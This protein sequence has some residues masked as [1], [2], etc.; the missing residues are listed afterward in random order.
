MRLLHRS[1]E[2]CLL[3]LPPISS[4]L[5][6]EI[7]NGFEKNKHFIIYVIDRN[8]FL[9]QSQ[10]ISIKVA[11]NIYT[12]L[13]TKKSLQRKLNRTPCACLIISQFFYTSFL[14]TFYTNTA[15]LYICELIY[16]IQLINMSN[17]GTYICLLFIPIQ[18]SY[19]GFK[20]ESSESSGLYNSVFFLVVICDSGCYA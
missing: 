6:T 12:Y 2:A 13:R 4:C 18:S 7:E 16:I 9:F 19:V 10:S 11:R 17:Q 15:L 5:N 1:F 3:I 20:Y 8:L 14:N